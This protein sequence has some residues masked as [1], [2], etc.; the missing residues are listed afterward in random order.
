[1]QILRVPNNTRF[2]RGIK[3]KEERGNLKVVQYFEIETEGVV[4]V[5]HL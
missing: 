2:A 3:C 4:G 1:M 5:V